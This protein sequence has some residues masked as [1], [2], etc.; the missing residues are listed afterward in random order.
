MVK[1]RHVEQKMTVREAVNR[2]I[3]AEVPDTRG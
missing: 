1:M 2:A 3:D